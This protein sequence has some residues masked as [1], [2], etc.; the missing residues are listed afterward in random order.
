M[1]KGFSL[2]DDLFNART[3]DMLVAGFRA[4]DPDFD[5]GFEARVLARF[6]ELEL[7]ER[8]NW[9]AECLIPA[10]PQDFPAAA[11]VIT[12]ALPPPLDPT[13]RDDD[14]GHFVYAALG[15]YAV[16]RGVPDH[17]DRLLDLIEALT[18]RFSMEFALRPILNAWPDLLLD[19]LK[20]WS[21]HDNYHVRRLVSEG[22]R[23]KLPWGQGIGLQVNQPLPLLDQLHADPTRFV[24][25]SVA[26]HLNDISKTAPDLVVARLTAWQAEG[27]QNAKEL[28]W[29]TRHALRG[30]VKSG[31]AGALALL[32]YR[33]DT[34]V[35]AALTLPASAQIGTAMEIAVD[36]TAPDAGE[37]ADHPV[38]IDYA[39]TF[40]RP[41]RATR[42]VY[43]LAVK[44]LKPGQSLRLSK[45][46]KLP[47]D[48]STYRIYPG[49]HLVEVM[50]NGQVRAK[51]V[52]SLSG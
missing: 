7:K 22:T 15:E 28:D 13:K 36:L 39:V 37:G 25:R 31:H 46:H 16:M 21:Q 52:I 17:P 9:I 5:P 43:K 33:V 23:P 1:A 18:Q 14:F 12:A 45:Q 24:T 26:N 44:T 49:D 20:G 51:S 2:K 4:R 50:I 30:L 8:I 41:T 35:Q 6:P 42:K 34:P 27:R 48:A 29:M 10:L 11:D 47:A 19:R 40:H 38:I 3:L 32:G